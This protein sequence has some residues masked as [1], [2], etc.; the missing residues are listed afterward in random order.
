M[1]IVVDKR[2]TKKQLQ[3]ELYLLR[4]RLA[5][6]ESSKFEN[7]IIHKGN[8]GAEEIYKKSYE[9]SASGM[10]ILTAEGIWQKA[11]PSMCRLLGYFEKELAATSIYSLVH[12]E[13]SDKLSEAVNQLLTGSAKVLCVEIR[14]AHKEGR[15][16]GV[17]VNIS[18]LGKSKDEIPPFFFIEIN[19][20][21]D[22]KSFMKIFTEAKNS[23]TAMYNAIQET[24]FVVD[25]DGIILNINETAARRHGES[26]DELVGQCVFDNIPPRIAS[27]RKKIITRVFE[28]GNPIQYMDRRDGRLYRITVC[29]IFDSQFKPVKAGV[30]AQDITDLTK[31]MT[32]L[33]EREKQQATV[34]KFGNYAITQKDLLPLMKKAAEVISL[35]LKVSYTGIWEISPISRKLEIRVA[36]ELVKGNIFFINEPSVSLDISDTISD[37]AVKAEKPLVI[38]DIKKEARFQTDMINSLGAKSAIVV[39]LKLHNHIYGTIAVLRTIKRS[40]SNHDIHFCEAIANILASAIEQ[41]RAESALK[42]SQ[43]NYRAIVED[44]TDFICRFST[45]GTITYVN[46]V[47]C[48][49]LGKKADE[50]CGMNLSKF[51]LKNTWEEVLNTLVKLTPNNPTNSIEHRISFTKGKTSWVNFKTRAIFDPNGQLIEFQS[52]G[53]DITEKNM[54]SCY[55]PKTKNITGIL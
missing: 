45:D 2:K 30:Y 32:G 17:C 1:L 34:A 11:N 55:W 41:N 37:Y 48:N 53:R 3:D 42:I 14:L 47:F 43:A 54:P 22:T 38:Q 26:I 5:E 29:P 52:V 25:T 18:I 51:I 46:N 23:F 9:L 20:I 27:R 16:I 4:K 44:Q 28:T 10:G 7:S 12:P 6:L 24:L 40:F 35:T 36:T 8:T 13:D 15:F 39:P 50:I 19:N 21:S 31:T 33:R 49:I